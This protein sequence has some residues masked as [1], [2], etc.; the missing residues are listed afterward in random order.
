MDRSASASRWQA[1]REPSRRRYR[2][3]RQ[4]ATPEAIFW[5]AVL[6]VVVVATFSS[7]CR[8]PD[9]PGTPA[10]APS[11][12]TAQSVAPIRLAL[13]ADQTRSMAGSERLT[14]EDVQTAIKIPKER[15]GDLLLLVTRAIS[16]RTPGP[17]LHIAPPDDLSDSADADDRHQRAFASSRNE[18]VT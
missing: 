16:A 5:L 8:K 6:C 18:T 14:L 1:G 10:L 15:G 2:H 11:G 7:G 9:R 12:S 3:G 4:F 17:S 13:M